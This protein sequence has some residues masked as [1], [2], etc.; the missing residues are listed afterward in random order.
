MNI[1]Y[2]VVEVWCSYPWH[3]EIDYRYVEFSYS[4][5]KFK[6]IPELKMESDTS[7]EEKENYI[8]EQLKIKKVKIIKI[9]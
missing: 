7:I 1:Y 6:A 2:K 5:K 3:N 4:K 9:K 8:K